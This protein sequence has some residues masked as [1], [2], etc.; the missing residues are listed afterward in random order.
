MI[1]AYI[2]KNQLAKA[3]ALFD[4][5]D[6][7]NVT[8]DV[9]IFGEIF[10]VLDMSK[11]RELVAELFEKMKHFDIQLDTPLFNLFLKRKKE[12]DED[13]NNRKS[14][15]DSHL[16]SIQTAL[17]IISHMRSYNL[18]PDARYAFINDNTT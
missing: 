14:S 2:D 1:K 10:C 12:T 8:P 4:R 18:Q 7:C 9:T 15:R 16:A 13:I 3:M 11:D 17:D 5:M 6:Q